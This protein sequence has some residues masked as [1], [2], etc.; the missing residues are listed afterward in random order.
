MF[1]MEM[2]RQTT[3]AQKRQQDFVSTAVYNLKNPLSSVL[4][5]SDILARRL[6]DKQQEYNEYIKQSASNM[7][8]IVNNLLDTTLLELE[9][10]KLKRIPVPFAEIVDSAVDMN[11]VQAFK[12]KQ[13]LT[14]TIDGEPIVNADPVRISEALDNLISNAIKYSP[15]ESE[16]TVSAA[17]KGGTVTFTVSDKGPGIAEEKISSI[18]EKFS[19]QDAR[20]TG[21]EG[22]TGLG[23]AITKKL[24]E[25]H[26][27][28]ISA[29]SAGRGKGSTFKIKLR[30]ISPEALE[31]YER[32]YEASLS[33]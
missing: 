19:G 16:I 2:R 18:F 30:A 33:R 14:V 24:V 11:K 5:F 17:R 7:L 12:K 8:E 28:T 3:L 9:E 1:E 31:E 25:L 21:G 15:A 26:G 22:S 13:H 20:A 32:N 10:I 27:G 23:L 4:G 6:E 29:E